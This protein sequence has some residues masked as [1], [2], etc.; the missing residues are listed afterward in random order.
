MR[1]RNKSGYQNEEN[2]FWITMT[3]LMLGLVLVFMIL[4]FYS[5]T[6]SYFE[7]V[8][9]QT[10]TG[11]INTQ[12]SEKLKEQKVDASVDLFSGVVNISDLEL[13]ELNS[14]ELSPKGRA[15]L[16]KFVPIYVNTIFANEDYK[17][18]ITGLVIQGHTD[19][20]TFA[21][22]ATPEEQYMKNMELSLKRAYSVASY[23]RHTSYDKKYS[24]DLEKIMLVE[25]CSYSK[26]VLDQ[27][28]KEDFSKSRRVELKLITAKGEA[29]NILKSFKKD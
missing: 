2:I 3:D 4:F 22:I 17:G 21:G 26:P 7:K 24:N 10:I 12:L 18:K 19:S 6:S 5:S 16:Q 15:Y 23:F 1:F 13:F 28:G 27:N 14:W 9:E 29:N 20:Q 25:G 11:N 8:R